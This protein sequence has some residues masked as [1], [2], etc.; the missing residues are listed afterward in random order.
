M[1]NNQ[2]PEPPHGN[3]YANGLE[4]VLQYTKELAII[5]FFGAWP[6]GIGIPR[7][8]RD[9]NILDGMSWATHIPEL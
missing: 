3:H 8:N 2:M 6:S 4:A 1:K 9:L 5:Q 7:I